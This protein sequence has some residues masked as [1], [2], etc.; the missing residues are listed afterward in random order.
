VLVLLNLL[1]FYDNSP[2]NWGNPDGIR[3]VKEMLPYQNYSQPLD[4]YHDMRTYDL[5]VKVASSMVHGEGSGDS[6]QH[7]EDVKLPE[8][9]PHVAILHPA[10]EA[11][12]AEA[13]GGP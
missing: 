4:L 13:E 9:C 12:D 11:A 10:R 3:C 5:V 6:D 1:P 2:H 7:H 8:G